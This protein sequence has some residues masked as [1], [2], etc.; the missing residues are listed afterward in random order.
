[1]KYLDLIKADFLKYMPW[2]ATIVFYWF[3]VWNDYLSS[4]LTN[5]IPDIEEQNPFAR[6]AAMRFVLH[7]GIVV[8]LVFGIGVGLTIWVLYYILKHWN[9]TFAT[10]ACNLGI[11]Y[12][13]FDRCTTLWLRTTFSHYG[14]MS[15]TRIQICSSFSDY[16]VCLDTNLS[17]PV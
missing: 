8:D 13:A 17:L 16:N 12:I 7:K 15:S 10:I 11:L 4:M 6:D 1:M 5:G 14:C 2:S 9:K 3:V